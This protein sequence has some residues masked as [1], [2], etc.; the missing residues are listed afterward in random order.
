[1]FLNSKRHID[2]RGAE[3]NMIKFYCSIAL[4]VYRKISQQ[5]F[6]YI[7]NVCYAFPA[8]RPSKPLT[9]RMYHAKLLDVLTSLPVNHAILPRAVCFATSHVRQTMQYVVLLTRVD[10]HLGQSEDVYL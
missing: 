9:L 10:M 7:I 5:L 6:Y 1:M 8:F 4:H 2:R 3:V